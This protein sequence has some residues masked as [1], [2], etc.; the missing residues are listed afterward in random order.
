MDDVNAPSLKAGAISD[1]ATYGSQASLTVSLT[2]A[3]VDMT[4]AENK[5]VTTGTLPTGITV[6]TNNLT[7]NGTAATQTITVANNVKVGTY[8]VTFKAAGKSVDVKVEVK[9]AKV[10]NLNATVADDNVINASGQVVNG[11]TLA[12][13]KAAITASTATGVKAASTTKVVSVSGRDV[14]ESYAPVAGEKVVVTIT[15]TANEGYDFTGAKA[16]A[17]HTI[18]GKVSADTTSATVVYTFVVANN[19]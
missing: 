15:Y 11:K 9:A 8:T 19:A 14:A 17:I 18:N 5:T 12:D 1:T 2:S 6:S 16:A 4:K 10:A 3:N 7:A 13:V